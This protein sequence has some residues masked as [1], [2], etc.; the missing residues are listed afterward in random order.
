M[1]LQTLSLYGRAAATTIWYTVLWARI[2]DESL[3]RLVDASMMPSGNWYA[4]LWDA[5]STS[6]P[7]AWSAA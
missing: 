2:Q 7:L 4:L 5:M 6:R 1:A 3:H